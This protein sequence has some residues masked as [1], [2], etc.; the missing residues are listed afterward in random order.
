MSRDI[1]ERFAERIRQLRHEKGMNQVDLS[2]KIGIQATYLSDLENAKKEPCLRV[3][4][5]LATGLGVP[6]GKLFK[7]L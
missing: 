4:D 2:E 5:L 3:I 6:L 1:V 7:D